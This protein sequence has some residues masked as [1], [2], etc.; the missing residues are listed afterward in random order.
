V[1]EKQKLSR[2]EIRH[3]IAVVSANKIRTEAPKIAP[4]NGGSN[5]L[6]HSPE[7]P[8]PLMREMPPADPF[9]TDALGK[10]L[11]K[12][13]R[14]I[15]DRTRAPIAMCAQSVLAAATLATQGHANVRLPTG[16]VRPIS[17]YFV[18]VAVSGE[19]K[20]AVDA[21]AT[22]PMT[23]HEATLRDQYGQQKLDYE[24]EKEAWDKARDHAKTAG[25]GNKAAIKAALD[26]L[27]PPLAE[28]PLPR[29]TC[30]EPTI[31]GLVKVFARGLPSLGLFSDEGGM[32]IGGHGLTLEAKLRTASTLSKFWD[33][34]VIDRVRGGEGAISLPGRRLAMHLMAQPEVATMLL[35]DDL[36]SDQ[37]LLSR[38][39]VT[40]PASTIGDRM[41]REASAEA[42][43]A[44]RAYGMRLLA[45]L[46][47]PLPVVEGK[48][49]ELAPRELELKPD[50]RKRWIEFHNHVE[51]NLKEEG[52]EL[53][54]VRGFANKLPEHAARLAA[55]LTLIED[56]NAP[57]I[58]DANMKRGIELAEHYATEGLRLFVASKVNADLVLAQR[59]RDWLNQ[60]PEDAISLPDIYQRGLNAIGDQATARRMVGLLVEHGWLT[61]INGSTIVAGQHR[62]EAWKIVR[63]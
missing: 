25:K 32:F 48:G 46:Q 52:G 15:Q 51:S 61:P 59:L 30:S 9:P 5:G 57:A 31:E 60:W 54:S 4:G 40:Y 53:W 22:W 23:K 55:V 62:R 2:E 16:Q 17:S 20:S 7:A 19:R 38:I 39:L 34:A 1:V 26:Q 43:A 18:S 29:L 44:I 3:R 27:G 49:N 37:G 47:R 12:A 21:Q 56:I 33:G 58:D 50:A 41:W 6:D 35:G 11:A 13:A 10:L 45:I 28:P 42:D 63:R 14:G 8:R 24:N 36:L